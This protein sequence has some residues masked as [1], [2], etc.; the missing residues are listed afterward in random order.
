M[1]K[2]AVIISTPSQAR[3]PMLR[4]VMDIN[5]DDIPYVIYSCFVLHNYCEAQKDLLPHHNVC[6]AISYD[7]EFQPP[8]QTFTFRMEANETEGKAIR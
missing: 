3:F 4:R 5:I 6:A 2:P 1:Y 7:R 8:T